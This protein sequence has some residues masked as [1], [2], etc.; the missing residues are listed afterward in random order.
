MT[1]TK[2]RRDFN[3]R[4]KQKREENKKA[5][6]ILEVTEKVTHRDRTREMK[7]VMTVSQLETDTG[8][9]SIT[10]E[11]QGDAMAG[12]SQVKQDCSLN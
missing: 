9:A 8:I 4:R 11:R 7:R 12:F 2:H 1:L 10:S 5:V 6:H 3:T